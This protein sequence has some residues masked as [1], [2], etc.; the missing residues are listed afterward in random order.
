[1]TLN[2]APLDKSD[3]DE[4]VLAF[5]NIGWNKPKNIYESYLTEQLNKQRSVIIAKQNGQFC[6]YV[7]LKWTPDYLSFAEKNIPEIADLNVLPKYRNQ[8]VGTALIKACEELVRE[9]RLSV[10]GI[11]VG[12]TVDYGN[13]QKLYIRLGFIPD[14]NGIHYKT[15][16]V[17]HAELVSVDD[18]LLLYLTKNLTP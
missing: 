6:G 11:G 15:K 10:I 18:D 16:P 12:L 7:T 1:M 5:K 4:I 17:K 3:V 8:G 9:R 2:L 14:G 13:A